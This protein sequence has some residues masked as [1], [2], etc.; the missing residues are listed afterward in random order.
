[1]YRLT[2][3]S[4]NF[5]ISS[6]FIYCNGQRGILFRV[7]LSR[8]IVAVEIAEVNESPHDVNITR[9]PWT[10]GGGRAGRRKELSSVV[11]KNKHASARASR[12][13]FSGVD[14]HQRVRERVQLTQVRCRKCV[15][16]RVREKR[17]SPRTRSRYTAARALIAVGRC[18]RRAR[19][20]EKEEQREAVAAQEATALVVEHRR[21]ADT[22]AVRRRWERDREKGIHR[23]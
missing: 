23:R 17:T 13:V 2:W 19:G 5:I 15:G 14:V 3:K 6:I 21:A 10:R 22:S 20:K 9:Q 16:G 7:M 18:R 1:M 12:V 11:S 8:E 4:F